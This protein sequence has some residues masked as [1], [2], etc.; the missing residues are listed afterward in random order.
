MNPALLDELK[1]L[2]GGAGWTSDPDA[3]EP[4]LTEWRDAIRGET[5]LML[6]PASTAQVSA[7]LQHCHRAGVGV[8]PQGGN[9]GLCGGAI[10]D[11]SGEQILLSL[12]RMRSIRHIDPA[13]FSITVDA[14]CVLADIQAAAREVLDEGKRNDFLDRVAAD[15]AFASVKSDIATLADPATDSISRQRRYSSCPL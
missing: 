12:S 10:P 5:P 11:T 15:E 6:M 8:V 14:G 13:D 2:V 1:A 3:L 4:H 9:T 7:V